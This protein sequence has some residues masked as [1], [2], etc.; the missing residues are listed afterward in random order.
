[1]Q[2]KSESAAV[3]SLSEK[4]TFLRCVVQTPIGA[5]DENS[6]LAQ[7][8]KRGETGDVREIRMPDK[9]RAL[10]L[11]ARLAGELDGPDGGGGVINIAL[12]GLNLP[13]SVRTITEQ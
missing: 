6:V 2:A 5:V 11:D 7:T 13:S 9:L 1:M 3:L 8:L 10:E 12:I 4:R